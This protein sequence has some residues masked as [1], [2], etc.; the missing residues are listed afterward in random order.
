MEKIQ[1]ADEDKYKSYYV[2]NKGLS[3][4]PQEYEDEY[5]YED[6]EDSEYEYYD[7]PVPKPKRPIAK[8]KSVKVAKEPKM[9]KK[10][11]TIL[12]R[13]HKTEELLN[14]ILAAQNGAKVQKVRKEV[15][16]VKRKVKRPT[17]NQ[18]IIQIPRAQV[19]TAQKKDQGLN[20]LMKLFN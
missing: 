12:Q 16:Q 10:D 8:G 15:R 19:A 7:E 18:T 4:Q 17:A 6:E 5:E 2:N 20:Q 1:Q 13:M 9:A 14:R 3:P 11:L